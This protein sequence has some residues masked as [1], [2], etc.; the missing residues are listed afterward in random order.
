MATAVQNTR[1]LLPIELQE[2]QK[3]FGSIIDF[4]KVQVANKPYSLLQGRDHVSTVKGVMYWP[5]SS[6]KTSLV[7][8]PHDAHVFI[9]EMVHVLQYQ[10]GVN[11]RREGCI[12]LAALAATGGKRGNPYEVKAGKA[13]CRYNV[14]EQAEL[15]ADAYC[16]R[17]SLVLKEPIEPLFP[18]VVHAP[19]AGNQ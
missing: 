2:A 15:V 5:N 4:S 3:V 16:Q 10:R 6:N 17:Y 18:D 9:H 14:E 12:A 11:V 19:T 7:E 1:A 8:T 13:W